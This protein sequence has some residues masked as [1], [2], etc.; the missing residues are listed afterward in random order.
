[1]V[2]SRDQVRQYLYDIGSG[3]GSQS[4]NVGHSSE[5]TVPT[6]VVRGV[7]W[8]TKEATGTQWGDL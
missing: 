2:S 3:L 8:A 5:A 6:C 1:M 4:P 7:K